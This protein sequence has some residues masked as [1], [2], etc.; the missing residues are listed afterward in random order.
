MC[1]AANPI[2]TAIGQV[3]AIFGGLDVLV[4]NA[5]AN[6]PADFDQITD[7]D[8]D[9]ILA[10]NLKGP[11]VCAKRPCRRCGGEAAG[12]SSTSAPSADNT[13]VPA[14]RITRPARPA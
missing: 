13:A 3:E 11:F 12:A 6:K 4:N 9:E 2:R 8:W 7:A 10:V 1:V 5:G 14:P